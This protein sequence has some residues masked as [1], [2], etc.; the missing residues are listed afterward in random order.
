MIR[1][2]LLGEEAEVDNSG[3]LFIAGYLT[4]LAILIVGAFFF[5]STL[6]SSIDE[7]TR[8]KQVL[9]GQLSQLKEVTQEVRDLEKK[10]DDLKAK[11]TVIAVLNK[12][13]SGPVRV[14]DALNMAV[15]ERAW[16]TEVS[17]RDHQ[18]KLVGL[19]LENLT[20]TTF[21]KQLGASD[22]FPK[23]DIIETKS[24]EWKGT[25]IKGFV[26]QAKVNY[27]G[28]VLPVTNVAAV[29]AG[30]ASAVVEGGAK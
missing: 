23:V 17:E 16:I 5:R 1:I 25:S 2:N 10:R 22:Y 13:K 18:M 9:E 15:P 21:A 19:A 11:L 12:N 8:S 14:I 6:V 3:T 4:S 24:T 26:M 30:L 20:V 7:L 27:S 29:G 28:R